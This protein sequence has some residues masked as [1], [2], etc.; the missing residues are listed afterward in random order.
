ML[1]AAVLL[2]CPLAANLPAQ[3]APGAAAGQ[4]PPTA[5]SALAQRYHI[6]VVDISYVFKNFQ[7]FTTQ[8]DAMKVDVE[9]MEGVLSK[10]RDAINALQTEMSTFNPGSPEYKQRD[11][12]LAQRKADF[13]IKAT[14]KRKEFLEREAKIY[15]QAYLEV[16]DAV[17]Y[18]AERRDIGLVLRFNGDMPP[19]ATQRDEV[20]RMINKPVVY[21][22]G[23]DITP[24]ILALLN[25]S[26]AGQ[27]QAN[28]PNPIPGQRR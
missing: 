19:D 23:I 18:Y 26:A 12:Q 15:F 7:R 21:Q 16:A 10:D 6:A 24:D 22:N 8:M 20:L 27:D 25:R 14:Q 1:M 11:E 4:A 28:R 3:Q 13:N 2:L 9:A 17:K 5:P